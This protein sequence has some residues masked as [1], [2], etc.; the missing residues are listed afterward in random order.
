[1]ALVLGSIVVVPACEIAVV[2]RPPFDVYQLPVAQNGSFAGIM[3]VVGPPP[4]DTH[5]YQAP[6]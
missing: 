2:L 4:R 3:A 1:M 6:A 5:M